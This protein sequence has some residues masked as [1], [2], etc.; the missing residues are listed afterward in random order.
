MRGT[1]AV[2]VSICTSGGCCC[3]ACRTGG[4]HCLAGAGSRRTS[5]RCRLGWHARGRRALTRRAQ[6]SWAARSRALTSGWAPPRLHPS[7]GTSASAHMWLI[8][9][10][11]SWNALTCHTCCMHADL[12]HCVQ[13]FANIF[14]G[15]CCMRCVLS[16]FD[17]FRGVEC[18]VPT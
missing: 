2:C 9:R 4:R 18:K 13:V 7:S 1:V 11:C 17:M 3:A 5:L 10:V 12:E 8:S 15:S 16:I 14:G 6:L